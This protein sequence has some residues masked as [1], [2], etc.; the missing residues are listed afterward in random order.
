MIKILSL[1]ILFVSMILR[2]QF[3]CSSCFPYKGLATDTLLYDI[4]F[5]FSATKPIINIIQYC[6]SPPKILGP[7]RCK[8]TS[9]WL[10]NGIV[11]VGVCVTKTN[12]D[13][14]AVP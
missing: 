10:E 7:I 4:H 2:P 12:V 1:S 8:Q 3:H 13:K 11:L 9:C 6:G 5:S 14:T